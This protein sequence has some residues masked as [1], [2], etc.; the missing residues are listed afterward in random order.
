[1]LTI[2]HHPLISPRTDDEEKGESAAGAGAAADLPGANPMK[3][4]DG[5]DPANYTGAGDS[6]YFKKQ[7]QKQQKRNAKKAASEAQ[8]QSNAKVAM[9][10]AALAAAGLFLYS[11]GQYLHR[12]S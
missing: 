2:P 7:F 6:D 10:V 9:G 1:M 8:L 5:I 3:P 12:L 4:G 11:S